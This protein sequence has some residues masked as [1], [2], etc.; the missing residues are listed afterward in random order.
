MV[1]L[2][3]TL[4]AE[5]APEKQFYLEEFRNRTLLLAVSGEQLQAEPDN[6]AILAEVVRELTG[7]GTRVFLLLGC[8]AEE[9]QHH[10]RDLL[11]SRLA[12][13]PE[14][15]TPWLFATSEVPPRW[16]CVPE[17]VVA[18][19]SEF[20]AR[21]WLAFRDRPLLVAV[22]PTREE[23][24]LA[25]LAT[26]IAGKLR[27]HKLGLVES[28]G[29]IADAAG[30]VIPYMDE[31]MLD[32]V[33]GRGQA[34]W[35][36]LGHR[37]ATFHAIRQALLQGVDSVNV[38]RLSGLAEEL[39]TYTGAGT[40]FT[41]TDYCSVQRLAIDDFAEVERLLA[42]G[43]AEGVLKP[44]TP[45]ETA[46]LLVHGYGAIVG[47][48]HLAGFCALETEAYTGEGAG[49]VAGLYT[50]TRFKGEGIGRKLLARVVT[51]ATA[52]GLRYLF[53]CTT[54]PHARA[55][56]EREGFHAVSPERVPRAKWAKYP[57]ERRQ[58][59]TVLRRD[60]DTRTLESA[61]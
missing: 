52:A 35:A 17:G 5:R 29:G 11:G 38:C 34:E 22:T 9:A 40:L 12:V 41:F 53:A 28:H 31:P 8:S 15:D 6:P 23:S 42:R 18:V 43:V 16:L 26:D 39:F 45:E 57:A 60:L 51:D 14:A 58:R 47:R 21:S 24:A 25:T 20:L 50:I 4:S 10:L 33:L 30:E 36:G 27:V 55:F 49:E 59:L 37:R 13:D 61:R 44:R 46:R 2:A 7:N 3:T 48:R 54:A 56:F 1:H 32:T 19:D